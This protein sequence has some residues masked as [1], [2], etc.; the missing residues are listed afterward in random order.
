MPPLS[1]PPLTYMRAHTRSS[2][3]AKNGTE[4]FPQPLWL[5]VETIKTPFINY[6]DSEMFP[7]CLLLTLHHS[8]PTRSPSPSIMF[9]FSPRRGP[10]VWVLL[11]RGALAEDYLACGSLM[12]THNDVSAPH[13]CV[14]KPRSQTSHPR[15][16]QYLGH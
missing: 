4:C 16:M 14:F 8:F 10:W 5:P 3:Q 9:V 11:T 1:E 13:F 12:T 6:V 7:D 2:K 15:H